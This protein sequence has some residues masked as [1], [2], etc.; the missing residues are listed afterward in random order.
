ATPIGP[1]RD[2][3][4]DTGLPHL[5]TTRADTPLAVVTGDE[6][7]LADAYRAH[8]RRRGV[9]ASMGVGAVMSTLGDFRASL[10]GAQLAL[11]AAGDAGGPVVSFAALDPMTRMLAAAASD[12]QLH[13]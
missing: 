4:A 7:T 1:V 12:G 6:A 2:V 13:Q 3:L 11:L 10:A 8:A 9:E 5:V